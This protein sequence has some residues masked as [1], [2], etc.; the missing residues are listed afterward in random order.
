[1]SSVSYLPHVAPKNNNT[2]QMRRR[3]NNVVSAV[4][5]QS[6]AITALQQPAPVPAPA[7]ATTVETFA[8]GGSAA[9]L[10][11][12]PAAYEVVTVNGRQY[13]RPLYY[14]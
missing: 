14:L 1:M 8:T 13:K 12:A 5:E 7:P 3:V 6:T 4:T 11:T 9:T 10:P 2:S